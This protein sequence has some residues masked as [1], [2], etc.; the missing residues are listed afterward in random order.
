MALTRKMLKAMG[1]EEEKIDQIIDAHTETVEGLKEE[2]KGYKADAEKLVGVRKE[3]DE[4]KKDGGDWQS[5]YEKEHADFEAYKSDITAKETKAAKAEAYRALLKEV[6]ISE[7]RIDAIVKI[8]DIDGIEL[9]KEGKI[10][11]AE[12]RTKGIMEDYA[13]FI[14]TT[15]EKGADMAKPPANGGNGEVKT[16]EEIY[17]R[18]NG[19]YVLSASERQAELV[20]LYQSEKGE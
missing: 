5:K 13:E 18:E 15:E 20:K 6:G 9:T 10:K 11:D 16:K 19:R 2:A 12:E 14:T 8:T 3:L 4:L 17:K 7:K 1:I